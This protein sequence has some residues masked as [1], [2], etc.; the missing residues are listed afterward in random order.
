MKLTSVAVAFVVA[1]MS[2]PAPPPSWSPVE[3]SQTVEWVKTQIKTI[4]AKTASICLTKSEEDKKAAK[5]AKRRRQKDAKDT[6][7]DTKKV[8]TMSSPS[9][10]PPLDQALVPGAAKENPEPAS[11]VAGGSGAAKGKTPSEYSTAVDDDSGS[12]SDTPGNQLNCANANTCGQINLL[13]SQ[14]LLVEDEASWQGAIWGHCLLCSALSMK[15][16]K[17]LARRRKEQR[18][19][20]LRGRRDRA[21]CIKFSNVSQIIKALF[22][23]AS[24]DQRRKLAEMRIKAMAASFLAGFNAS[25]PCYQQLCHDINQQWFNEVDKCAKDPSYA[26]TVDSQTLSAQECS[27]LTNLGKGTSLSFLCR[28]PNCLYYSMN[29]EWVESLGSYHFKCPRCGEQFRPWTEYKG[30]AKAMEF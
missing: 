25:S 23:G 8:E 22:P 7:A 5:A 6:N 3:E 19:R 4:E 12:E 24:H 15:E 28:M 21:R 26:C 18:A 9:G 20:L 11:C 10:T 13:W 27:Y 1:P 17:K 14:F 30:A 16:F 29:H 2:A